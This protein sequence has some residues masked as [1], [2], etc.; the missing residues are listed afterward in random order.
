ML[1]GQ[2]AL[3]WAEGHLPAMTEL[4]EKVVRINSHTAN[5]PG[6]DAVGRVFRRELGRLGLTLN[7]IA[8]PVHGDLLLATT[9]AVGRSKPILLCG[10]MDTVFP[11][12]SPFDWFRVDGGKCFGPGTADMKGG[13]VV[14]L[15]ALKLLAARRL[16]PDIPLLFL[17][18]SEEEIGSPVSG[19]VIVD[20]A[21]KSAAALV[22]ECG[23]GQGE[24][25]TA[26]KGKLGL[27]LEIKGQAGHAGYPGDA[28]ASALLELA[29]KIIALEQLNGLIPGLTVNVGKAG[30]G[31]G[32]NVV[33]EYAMAEIDVRLPGRTAEKALMNEVGKVE[34]RNRVAGVQS[35]F[36]TVGGRPMMPATAGNL[37]L[38]ER[39]QRQAGSLGL[40]IASEQRGGVSDANTIAAQG[41]PVLDGMGPVGGGDHSQDEYILHHSLAQRTALAA[42]LIADLACNP[43]GI[44]TADGNQ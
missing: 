28:K 25:V 18:N 2:L 40:S 5:K 21:R 16:L 32:P 27:H 38:W 14:A 4:L 11:V 24:V 36:H 26:R 1:E 41:T 15:F 7:T 39:L 17:L 43:P 23:G 42:L 12:N 29:H 6:V 35:S 44:E 31:S 9:T 22:F 10:H 33:P 30:G 13:L 3:S 19:P 37:A 20:L 34:K 8:Q